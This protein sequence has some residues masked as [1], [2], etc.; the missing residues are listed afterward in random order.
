M[1]NQESTLIDPD[2]YT[3]KRPYKINSGINGK[4]ELFLA[5][6]KVKDCYLK[7]NKIEGDPEKGS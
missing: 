2:F 3:F 5:D 1:R 4:D 6:P 7:F